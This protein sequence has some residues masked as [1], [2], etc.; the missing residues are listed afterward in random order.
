[1][2]KQLL[3]MGLIVLC[4]CLQAVPIDTPRLTLEDKIDGKSF[5]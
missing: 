5:S 4:H 1:M 3:H 2:Y